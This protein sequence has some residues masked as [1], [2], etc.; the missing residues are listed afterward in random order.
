[1]RKHLSI[2]LF[3]M[4]PLFSGCA[5][6][7]DDLVVAKVG[8]KKLYKSEVLRFIPPGLP[9][10]DSL[11]IASQYIN[12]W[13]GELIMNEMA[14]SQLNKKEKDVSAEIESYRNSLLRYRYEQ[15]YIE[16]HLDKNVPDELILERY[17]SS[18]KAYALQVPILKVRY[19]Q[20]PAASPFKE[21]IK[22]I[23]SPDKDG[24]MACLDSLSSTAITK[25]ID[26]SDKWI[27]IVTLARE[28]GSDYSQL[29]SSMRDSF[30]DIV[31]GQ[32]MEHLSY[33]LEF[34][35][36]GEVPPVEYCSDR[37]REEIV[38]ERRYSLYSNLERTL[39]D[40]ALASGK[41]VIYGK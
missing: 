25:F 12:A 30:I 33:V 32:G 14:S 34:I 4:M 40:D 38:S 19:A 5:F 26:F 37:I 31:D 20:F 15:R 41:F 11:S 22:G 29:L 1:M 16:E 17:E 7:H 18:P 36:A 6:L 24:D 35:K 23:L 9:E 3:S 28:Y 27:D 13:A 39:I 10:E 21:E 2:V 8:M